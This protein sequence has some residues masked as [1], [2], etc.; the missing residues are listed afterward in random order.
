MPVQPIVYSQ[1]QNTTT[2]IN[3]RH[4]KV[5]TVAI[6]PNGQLAI[7]GTRRGL[8][9]IWDLRHQQPLH[10]INLSHNH[11]LI[12]SN[13]LDGRQVRWVRFTP[14][15]QTALITSVFGTVIIWSMV[16]QTTIHTMQGYSPM[17]STLLDDTYL[18]A[19]ATEPNAALC[20]YLR[21][22]NIR[23][24]RQARMIDRT[25]WVNAVDIS[26]QQNILCTG[27]DKGDI[28]LWNWYTGEFIT[29]YQHPCWVHAVI[30]HPTEPILIS[31]GGGFIRDYTVQIW[32]TTTGK[33]RGILAGHDGRINCMA[34]SHDGNT[35]VT[36]SSDC[37][38]KIWDLHTNAELAALSGHWEQIT[39]L[40]ISP[41]GHY[42]LSGS[43][44]GTVR[45]WSMPAAMD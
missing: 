43:Y 9:T 26:T 15:S 25:D 17:A 10:Q 6:S 22:G 5:E 31:A 35:L 38:I 13:Q 42:I 19:G 8:A 33:V 30:L 24:G 12:R 45:I 40:A 32:D 16:L 7:V 23:T 39:S 28:K 20:P 3:D 41:N 2:L 1:F 36:G 29:T 18:I 4:N 37:K 11:N 27:H 21:I 44:D 14:D 34:L